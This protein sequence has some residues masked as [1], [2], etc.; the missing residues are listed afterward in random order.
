ML[1]IKKLEAITTNSYKQY[2]HPLQQDGRLAA[3]LALHYDPERFIVKYS[4]PAHLTIQ[5]GWNIIPNLGKTAHS[6]LEM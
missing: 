6:H 1:R 2:Q 4:F 5:F 3:S